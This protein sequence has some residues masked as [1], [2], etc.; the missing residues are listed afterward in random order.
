MI[1]RPP[2]STRTDTLFPYT[3]LCR[4]PIL[5]RPRLD[6]RQWWWG[7]QFLR[8][9]LPGRL[10]PNIRAMVRMSEYSRSTLQGM[11]RELGIEYQHLERGI[12]NFY[13]DQA[14]FAD[15]PRMV[16]VMRRFGVDRRI[17][18]HD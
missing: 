16:G 4:S 9:C 17:A 3:T 13:R 18:P 15:S 7:L 10:A 2:R 8:E 11:R 5:F 1:R 12:L 14:A 6:L